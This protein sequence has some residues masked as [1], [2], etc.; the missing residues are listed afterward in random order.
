MGGTITFG[1]KSVDKKY[2]INTERVNG[3]KRYLIGMRMVSQL[4]GLKRN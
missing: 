1:Y 4:N 2:Q 3:L